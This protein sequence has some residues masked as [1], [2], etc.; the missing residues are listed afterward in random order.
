MRVYQKQK[1]MVEGSAIAITADFILDL[2]T[3]FI[4]IDRYVAKLYH[5]GVV[6]VCHDGPTFYCIKP[7]NGG[8]F[9]YPTEQDCM[10]MQAWQVLYRTLA[11]AHLNIHS[12]MIDAWK[13][14]L[15]KPK[16]PF[17]NS[18]DEEEEDNEETNC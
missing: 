3:S 12:E 6:E 4:D 2:H 9:E 16:D 8:P 14:E 17:T 5:E 1:M 11:T 10:L 13:S 7:Q 15:E 18:I